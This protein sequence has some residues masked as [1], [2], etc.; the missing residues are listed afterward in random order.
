MTDT[1]DHTFRTCS[2]PGIL[3][4]SCWVAGQ[5]PCPLTLPLSSYC[6]RHTLTALTKNL[7]HVYMVG[8]L[9]DQALAVAGTARQ[10]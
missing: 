2:H 10:I 7:H 8:L 3:P 5:A 6:F 1:C 9:T 4:N